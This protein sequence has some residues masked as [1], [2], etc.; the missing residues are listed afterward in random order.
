MRAEGLLGE[1]KEKANPR[2]ALELQRF[3]KTGPGE[4]AEG[5]LFLGITVPTSRTIARR[6]FDL[7][8]PDLRKLLSSPIHEARFCALII[9]VKRFTRS[10]TRAEEEECFAFYMAHLREGRINN[11]DLV[12]VSAPTIGQYLLTEKGS[13]QVLTEMAGSKNL[14]V[15]R[16]SILFTFAAL[17]IGDTKPTFEISTLLLADD[18]DL[19]QKAVGWALREAGKI[20]PTQLRQ[21]LEKHGKKMSRTTLRYAIEKF[22]ASERKNW[23]TQTR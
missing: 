16:S 1:L 11:W 8:F 5:D 23:L 22:T 14:W 10:Q 7:S 15:R 17:R 4:Y 21:Y 2:K 6:Y 12:D 20:S 18:Q 9:L 13:R 3:F 19:M